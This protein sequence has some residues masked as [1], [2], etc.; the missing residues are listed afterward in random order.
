MQVAT[1]AEERGAAFWGIGALKGDPEAGPVAVITTSGTAVFE[2]TPAVQEAARMRLPLVLITADRPFE[3]KGIGANQTTEQIGAFGSAAVATLDLPAVGGG[4]TAILRAVQ[5]R[6]GRLMARVGGHGGVPGPAH[7]N[8]AFRDP[9]APSTS[10]FTLPQASVPALPTVQRNVDRDQG[11]RWSQVV[12]PGRNVIVVAGDGTGTDNGSPMR[13]LAE[14]A[15]GQGIPLIAEPSSGLTDLA[16]WLPHGPLVAERL[17]QAVRS[18][19]EDRVEQ[20][21]VLGRPTLSRQVD[22]LVRALAEEEALVVVSPDEEW[23]GAAAMNGTVVADLVPDLDQPTDSGDE[24]ARRV[25]QQNC[26]QLS[27][28]IEAQLWEESRGLSHLSAARMIWRHSGDISLWLSASNVVRAFDIGSAAPGRQ[29]VFANRGLAGIDGT[30]ASALG[31]QFARKGPVRVVVG[32]LAFCYD[33]PSLPARPSGEQD[34][35]IIVFD[36][37]EGSIFRTLEHGRATSEQMYRKFFGVPQQ[38]DVCAVARACG[39]H[40]QSVTTIED[41]RDLVIQPIKGRSLIHIP[42]AAPTRPFGLVN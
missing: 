33:L 36:D 19:A 15:S 6:I 42:L 14:F 5:G 23:P 35:Q 9:L 20:I 22:Q 10:D 40:A 29:A 12:D 24:V 7:I 11:V 16:S 3:L 34:I 26:R 2:M 38:I 13:V 32:D 4:E 1:F 27:A 39:W 21:V 28:E 41:L 25:W 18:G 37:Q 8:V 17:L 30:V 31:L